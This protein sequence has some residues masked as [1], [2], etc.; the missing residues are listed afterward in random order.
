LAHAL[1]SL[2]FD[3]SAAVVSLV[4]VVE[5]LQDT[6]H[7]ANGQVSGERQVGQARCLPD[8]R[9]TID[10]KGERLDVYSNKLPVIF[11]NVSDSGSSRSYYKGIL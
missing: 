4:A 6:P 8:L 7:S 11:C 10:R 3:F 1:D 2:K 9:A 5:A